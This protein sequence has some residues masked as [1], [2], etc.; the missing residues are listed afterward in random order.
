MPAEGRS[1]R[2]CAAMRREFPKA[3]KVAVMCSVD[4]CQRRVSAAGLCRTHYERNRLHES[5]LAGGRFYGRWG[6]RKEFVEKALN[7]TGD[8]CLL[9]PFSHNGNGYPSFQLGKR[10][11]Y[12]HRVVC[13]A[14]NGPPP[15]AGAEAAHSC[16]N[17][18]LGCI[19]PEHL[20]WATVQENRRDTVLMG[21]TV[22]G[23]RQHAAKLTEEK[24]RYALSMKGKRSCK[25]LGEELGVSPQSV[26][27]IWRGKSWAWLT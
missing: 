1:F 14:L 17:G 11:Q 27:D 15:F 8:E 4:G 26:N 10:K 3:V 5:P 19:A 9:W 13:E 6:E 16:G 20:R 2:W 7:Y 21:R 25:K 18:H 12:A 23:E 22:R 24:A